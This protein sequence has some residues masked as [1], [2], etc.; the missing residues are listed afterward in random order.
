MLQPSQPAPSTPAP[1][2]AEELR[3]LQAAH[4]VLAS[5]PA[6]ALQ[7]LRALA[8]D[9]P[10]GWLDEERSALEVEALLRLGQ[11][12]DAARA[13]AQLQTRHPHAAALPRLQRALAQLR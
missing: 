11:R 1:D 7:R 6:L 9:Y 3:A 5:D 8:R 4:A 13:L 2:R 12:D 10:S